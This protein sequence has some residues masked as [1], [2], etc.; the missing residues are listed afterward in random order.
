LEEFG[1]FFD[2]PMTKDAV[3]GFIR[4]LPS[5]AE[6]KAKVEGISDTESAVT[7]DLLEDV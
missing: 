5:I 6:R 1:R 2:P 4:R 3:A 7:P